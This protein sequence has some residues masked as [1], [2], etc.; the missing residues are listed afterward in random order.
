MQRAKL[1]AA[2]K[3]SETAERMLAENQRLLDEARAVGEQEKALLQDALS[4]VRDLQHRLHKSDERLL[5][6]QQVPCRTHASKHTHTPSRA[7]ART[8]TRKHAALDLDAS[9]NLGV[10]GAAGAAGGPIFLGP[11]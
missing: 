11:L 3:R 10:R 2:Y 7:P 6:T 1:A 9:L 8:P 5:E 4:Q